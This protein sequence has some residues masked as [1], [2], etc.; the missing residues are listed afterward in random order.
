LIYLS[1]LRVPLWIV[2]KA[3]MYCNFY[4]GTF[5]NNQA[6]WCFK[7]ENNYLATWHPEGLGLQESFWWG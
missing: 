4:F 3:T 1:L 5:I 6:E 7:T 2:L